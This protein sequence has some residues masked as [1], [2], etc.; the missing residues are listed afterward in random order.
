MKQSFYQTS[1]LFYFYVK[2]NSKKMILWVVL[3]TALT[4]M[5]PTAFESMYPSQSKMSPIIEMSKN[6]AMQAMLGPADFDDVNIGV[7]FTHEMT[8]FTAIMVAIM[9]ILIVSRDTRGDEEDGRIIIL[10]ALPIGK[11]APLM[12]L[13]IQTLLLN[14]SLIILLTLGLASL[15]VEGIDLVGA[16]LYSS[17][18]G[19]FGIMFAAL[20]M[21]VAQFVSSSSETTGVSIDLLLIMYLIRAFG[22]VANETLS[23]LSPMGWLSRTYAFS[24]DH[25]WPVWYMKSPLGLQIRLQKMSFIYF[26]IG[27]FILG[28]SYGSIFGNL[29]DFFKDNP[30]LL[31]MLENPNGDYVK[32]FLPQLMLVMSIISTVPTLLALFKIKKAIDKGYAMLVLANPLSRIKYLLSFLIISV[33]NA[34]VMIFV[35]GLG[36]YVGQFYSMDTPLDFD[37][38][39]QSAIVYIPAIL[40]FVGIGT[41]VIGWGIKL[42]TLVYAYLAYTFLVNYL[43]TLLNVKDWM[44]DITPFEHIPS[45]PIDDFTSGPMITLLLIFI[46]LCVIGAFGFNRKDI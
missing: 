44:K 13:L 28:L 14:V 21:F 32:Q 1:K 45:L 42:T 18:L 2:R 17:T 16:F 27:L 37:M 24:E 20:T 41:V 25:W 8:L 39:I 46:I 36:L 23:M 4:L 19:V 15:N 33:V 6:P 40:S 7:L 38:V 12:G 26:A 22:D 29:D 43:G 3:L 9:N 35:A 11:Q 30:L 34:V 5:I 10:T 31:S